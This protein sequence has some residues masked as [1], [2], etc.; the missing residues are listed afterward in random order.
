LYCCDP[1]T[2]ETF[3]PAW[4]LIAALAAATAAAATLGPI[5]LLLLQVI[6]FDIMLVFKILLWVLHSS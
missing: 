4:P 5:W 3:S 2:Y 6:S 1:I